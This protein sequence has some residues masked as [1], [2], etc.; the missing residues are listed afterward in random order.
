MGILDWILGRRAA[1]NP[2]EE[3]GASEALERIIQLTNPRLQY[4]R[5]FRPRLVPAVRTAMDYARSMLASVPPAREAST[6]AW[7]SDVY[8]RAFF[9]TADDLVRAFSRS[10]ELRAWFDA[11]P[12][13]QE[14]SVVLSMLLVERKM[15]GVVLV[16]SEL[17]R[18]VPQITVSFTDY[19]ARICG[20]SESELR[21]DIERRIVDQLALT[22]MA[23]AMEDQSRRE[24]LE[25]ERALLRA[26]MRMLE[27]Q[28]AGL[29]ALGGQPVDAEKFDRLHADLAVNEQNLKV[30]A[31]GSEALD[32]QLEQI[33][34]VLASPQEH[35]FLSSKRLR[36]NSM[37]IELHDDDPQPAV[38]LDLQLARVPMPDA[39][40]EMRTFVLTRFPRNALLPRGALLSEAARLL[41]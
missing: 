14:V 4:A 10:P 22:G 31:T 12:A 28:G 41:G 19:R 5:R 16:G 17:Q 23:K 6:Q 40:A 35:F 21:Q 39:P 1:G 27:S 9:A 30:L 26:R 13:A 38:N 7:Q 24:I 25:Q 20:P 36:L 15:L 32:Y 33:R 3:A 11:N 2:A 37:N 18:D 34:Q 29:T 8:M